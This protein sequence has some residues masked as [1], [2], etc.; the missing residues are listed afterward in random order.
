MINSK[1][2][3][4]RILLLGV[5]AALAI[6][7]NKDN[8]ISQEQ[9][10]TQTELKT[11][12]ETDDVSRVADNVLADIYNSNGS[13]SAKQ[14]DC[15]SAE[16]SETGFTAT[17]NNCVLNGS[18]DVNGTLSVVYSTEEGAAAYIATFTNFYVGDIK[19]NGTR[20]YEIEG[21]SEEGSISFTITS[22]L[23]IVM[24]DGSIVAESGTKSFGIDFG[25][26]LE[27]TIY[28]IGGNWTLQVDG[29][30][31][32]VVIGSILE[33]NFSCGYLTNGTM[34]VD[35]NGLVVTV[36]LG[37]GACDDK[38]TLTYPNGAIEEISLKD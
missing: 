12:L 20:G 37:D 28:T 10:L 5:V 33:G 36:G 15:Y 34:T 22:N 27:T 1:V 19:I 30:T 2:I 25:D 24:E 8:E 7:C 21:N 3:G 38:V 29:Q 9:E 31:Y 26:N 35:K 18:D 14:S 13:P 17:F 23:T 32:K 4:N 6:S 11:I 16:Y